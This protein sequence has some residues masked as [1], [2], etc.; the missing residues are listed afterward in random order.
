M[1]DYTR[2]KIS[3]QL[4]EL[5]ELGYDQFTQTARPILSGIQEAQYRLL[6][7]LCKTPM[8]SMT[9]L[10]KMM[11]I[12]KPYMTVLVDILI[13]DGYV[14][15]HPDPNDRRVINVKITD[16]G[17]NKLNDIRVLIKENIMIQINS[18]ETSDL[19]ALADSAETIIDICKKYQK[20]L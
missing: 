15:R 16:A 19:K 12:S 17:R 11:Y 14:E 13:K 20:N 9:N 5:V 8:E 10:G 18:M 4:I 6:F 7:Y 1:N 3:Q 2:D